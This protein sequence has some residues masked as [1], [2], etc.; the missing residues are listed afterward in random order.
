MHNVWYRDEFDQEAKRSLYREIVRL[1]LRPATLFGKHVFW[2]LKKTTAD[3]LQVH[4]SSRDI[5]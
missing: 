1:N 5:I 3:A 2:E 4:R